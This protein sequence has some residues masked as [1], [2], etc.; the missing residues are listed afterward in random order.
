MRSGHV[1]TMRIPFSEVCN[2]HLQC[3][4]VVKEASRCS[5]AFITVAAGMRHTFFCKSSTRSR[6]IQIFSLSYTKGL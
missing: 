6:Q 3:I 2:T 5:K 4:A 1:R